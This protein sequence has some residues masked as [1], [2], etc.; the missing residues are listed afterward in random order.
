MLI[1]AERV[2]RLRFPLL[3]GGEFDIEKSTPD[4]FDL[5]VFY[6]GLH[7]RFCVFHLQELRDLVNDYLKNGVAIYVVSADVLERADEFAAKVNVPEI[8]FG[9]QL[10]LKMAREWDLYISSG[11]GKTSIQIV[12][13]DH[14]NEPGLFLVKLDKTLYYGQ[15]QTMPFF[16]PPFKDLLSAIYFSNEMNYPARGT[17]T[18][19]L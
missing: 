10:D 15:V 7:C 2:P 12:E 1:P 19:V 3:K 16:R 17:Y 6:R 14:F 18:G 9:Y 13:P 11:R 4:G 5:I 8:N